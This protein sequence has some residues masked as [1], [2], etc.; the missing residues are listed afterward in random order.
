MKTNIVK[1]SCS[2]SSSTGYYEPI[3][4]FERESA[5]RLANYFKEYIKP[6]I[7][8]QTFLDHGYRAGELHESNLWQIAANVANPRPFSVRESIEVPRLNVGLLVDCSG[9]MCQATSLTRLNGGT[10][11]YRQVISAARILAL[12]LS[13]SLADQDGIRLTVGGHTEMGGSIHLIMCKRAD[14][15]CKEE[16]FGHLTAQSGNL[17]G[18]ALVA[19]AKEMKKTMVPGENGLI[20]LISDG[21]PC[22]S[23][24][25]MQ[26]AFDACRRLYDLRILPIGVGDQTEEECRHI[27]N[28]EDFLIA[29]NVVSCAPDVTQKINQ[30]VEELKPM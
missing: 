10:E 13:L 23:N 22:H 29:N 9:S 27:Y 17:D 4:S 28:G 14:T 1:I 16:N 26:K 25:V 11:T 15:E 21:A 5:R 20:L 24:D 6:P 2:S 7:C 18:L 19:F 3:D 30:L 12:G 8:E